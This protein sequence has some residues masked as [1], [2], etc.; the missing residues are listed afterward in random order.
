MDEARRLTAPAGALLV[1]GAYGAGLATGLARFPDPVCVAVVAF[2]VAIWRP[3]APVWPTMLAL[4]AG[5]VVGDAVRRHE[6]TSCAAS[7]PLG[8]QTFRLRALEPGSG[9]GRV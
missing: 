4:A 3:R 2:V 1:G 9:S 5:I 8:E 6:R 7:L